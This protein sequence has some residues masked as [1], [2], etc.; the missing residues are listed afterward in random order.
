[1]SA[2]SCNAL[3]VLFSFQQ[4]SLCLFAV[5]FFA[6]SLHTRT[7]VARLPTIA[8]ARLSCFNGVHFLIVIN[9]LTRKLVQ[10]TR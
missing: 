6:E 9:S 3:N 7:A 2:A 10:L 1:M 4:N 5:D 8:L